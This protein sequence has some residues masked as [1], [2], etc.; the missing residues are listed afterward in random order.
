MLKKMKLWCHFGAH[1]IL[2]GVPKSTIFETIYIKNNEKKE[3]H[4]T[5]LKKHDFL[6]DFYAKMRGLK[7]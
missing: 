5:A 3:V 2:K 6:I 4:E 7:L 1:R